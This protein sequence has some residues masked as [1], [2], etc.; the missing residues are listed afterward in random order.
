MIIRSIAAALHGQA[1]SAGAVTIAY[2]T[3]IV[4]ATLALLFRWTVVPQTTPLAYAVLG[5]VSL[6]IFAGAIANLSSSTRSY[7]KARPA[8]LRFLFL[9]VHVSQPALVAAFVEPT[10]WLFMLA[11]Y[12]TALIG[13]S[14]VLAIRSDSLREAAAG[15]VFALGTATCLT[16]SGSETGLAWFAPVYLGKLVLGFALGTAGGRDAESR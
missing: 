13:G 10:A 11:C 12:L 6:D 1:P 3:G 9:A 5:I 15:S 14:V 2:L 8:A 4:G 7:Y 16:L